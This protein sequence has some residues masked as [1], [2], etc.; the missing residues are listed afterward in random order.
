MRAGLL[1]SAALAAARRAAPPLV[2]ARRAAASTAIGA[3]F[4][5]PALLS[6]R[7]L[8]SSAKPNANSDEEVIRTAALHWQLELQSSTG[9][10]TL[11]FPVGAP[12]QCL[13]EGKW[14]S[15]TVIA[16]LYRESSW[17]EGRV[18]PYQVLLSEPTARGNALWSPADIDQCIRADL[19]FGI[20][21]AV[22]CRIDEGRWVPGRV[23]AHF[24]REPSWVEGRYAPYQVR[25]EALRTGG[26]ALGLMASGELIWAPNDTD[27]CIRDP[28][29]PQQISWGF[30]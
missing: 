1:R 4:A 10:P 5:A 3:A 23:V 14:A 25:L 8:C 24:H 29:G 18:V 21:A 28:A 16:H 15:G 17:P 7:C 6:H 13:V 2:L 26:D 30:Q 9:S 27:D 11:R 22:E 20:G 19:R 12:V